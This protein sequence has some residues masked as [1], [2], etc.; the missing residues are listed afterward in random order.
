MST[1][2]LHDACEEY[3]LKVS[4]NKAG[5]RWE[6]IRL[7]KFQRDA[8]ADHLLQDIDSDEVERWIVQRQKAGLANNSVRREL[9]LLSAVFEAAIKWRWTDSNPVKAAEKPKA[10]AARS[11]RISDDEIE[12]LSY[13]LG[14]EENGI[15]GNAWQA[16]G[17]AFLLAIETGMRQGEIYSRTA[18]KVIQL[19]RHRIQSWRDGRKPMLVS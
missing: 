14:Y 3:S 7:K 5:S 13:A 12:R 16:L 17:V 9:T 1:K 6:Q 15:V 11:R 19:S 18:K 2:T 8:L 10:G 4:V